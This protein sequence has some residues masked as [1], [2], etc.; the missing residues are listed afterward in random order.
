MSV[1]EGEAQQPGTGCGCRRDYRTAQEIGAGAG[2]CVSKI[3]GLRSARSADTSAYE[4]FGSRVPVGVDPEKVHW[5]V[6]AKVF[7]DQFFAN[8]KTHRSVSGKAEHHVRHVVGEGATV[9]LGEAKRRLSSDLVGQNVRTEAVC[10]LQA[11]GS[12]TPRMYR[13]LQRRRRSH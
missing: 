1:G 6:P 4:S 8:S 2:H 9:P 13:S 3:S 7:G 11:V 12:W 10:H 5:E